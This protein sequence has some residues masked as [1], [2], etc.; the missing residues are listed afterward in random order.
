MFLKGI[1]YSENC[2]FS[3]IQLVY[4]PP[5]NCVFS[6]SLKGFPIVKTVY[7]PTFNLCILHQKLCI[8]RFLKGFPIVKTVY[9]P[10]FNLCIL[11]PKTVYSHVP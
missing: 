8:L 2:V 10:T 4:S 7:S 5:K 6:G 3:N 11:L 9:S 1:S